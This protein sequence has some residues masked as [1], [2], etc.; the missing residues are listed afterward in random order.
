[1]TNARSNSL[2]A[3]TSAVLGLDPGLNITGWA[4]LDKGGGEP[5]LRG[6]GHIETV[7]GLSLGE[8]LEKIFRELGGVI[9]KYGPR[10][11]AVE[12]AYLTKRAPS[13]LGT[14]QARGVILLACRLNGLEI[15]SYNPRTV[16]KTVTGDGDASK[17]HVQKIIQARMKMKDTIKPDDTADAVAAALCHCQTNPA[18]R[19]IASAKKDMSNFIGREREAKRKNFLRLIKEKTG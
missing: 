16:K 13:Q 4:V 6:C 19:K 2:M 8:R 3:K 18:N 11:A 14:M 12:E 7:P 5:R 15:I 17:F 1:M 9:K 10:E